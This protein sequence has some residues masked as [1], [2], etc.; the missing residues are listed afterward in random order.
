MRSLTLHPEKML[1][2]VRDNTRALRLLAY[3]YGKGSAED[4]YDAS[5]A[6][7]TSSMLPM[8]VGAKAGSAA[9]K[10]EFIVYH[11]GAAELL[12]L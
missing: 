5:Q 12:S 11:E 7:H 1:C 3:L 4:V 9:S 8:E 2:W 10:N 6:R